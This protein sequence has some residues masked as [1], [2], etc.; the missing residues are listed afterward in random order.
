MSAASYS[1][2]KLYKR[3][4][5]ICWL[6]RKPCPREIATR[7]HVIPRSHGGPNGSHNL[8]IA[9][10]KCNV[11][12]DNDKM[13]PTLKEKKNILVAVQ[14]YRCY[15][16]NNS[17]LTKHA[18]IARSEGLFGRLV[19]VHASGVGCNSGSNIIPT[20]RTKVNR[21]SKSAKNARRIRQSEKYRRDSLPMEMSVVD[22][23]APYQVEPEDYVRFF[24]DG[25]LHFGMVLNVED[26]GDTFIITLSDDVEGDT[27]AYEVDL[28]LKIGLLA[29]STVMI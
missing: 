8:R 20:Q 15:S 23:L 9:H 21:N 7:D 3:D 18:V 5:G 16:C 10:P 14:G 26:N 13:L 4:N 6:C 17:I 11:W 2:D 28:D 29:H 25:A 22:T 27:V 12:R 24:S 1:L 19:L